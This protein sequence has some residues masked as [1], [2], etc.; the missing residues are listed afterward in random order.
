M[1]PQ[2]LV[3]LLV[4]VI[5]L[6]GAAAMFTR[7]MPAL[8][9]LPIMAVAIVSGTALLTQEISFRQDILAGVIGG[10]STRL[11]TAIIVAFFGGFLS[12]VMQKTGVAE[13][14]IKNAAE[15]IG[16]NPLGVSLFILAIVALLFTS[17]GGLGAIIMVA[18]V[19]L[20]MLSTVGVPPVVSGGILLI[21]IS[22]GGVLNPGNWVL[23]IEALQVPVVKVRAFALTVFVLMSLAGTIFV[24]V[25]LYRARVVRSA[26][27]ILL[28]VGIAIVLAGAVVWGFSQSNAGEG[29]KPY[30]LELFSSDFSQHVDIAQVGGPIQSTE[31]SKDSASF[32]IKT[33]QKASISLVATKATDTDA[34]RAFLPD[35]F[36]DYDRLRFTA[37]S[38]APADLT[39]N[40]EAEDAEPYSIPL[41]G[42]ATSAVE[43]T[44]DD[45]GIENPESIRGLSLALTPSDAMTSST[46]PTT[47]QITPISFIPERTV[48]I[49]KRI[50]QVLFGVFFAYLALM[51][52]MDFRAKVRRWR[53]Q[54][55]SIKWYA[56]LIPLV[57]LVMILIY[58]IDILAAF[59]IGFIYAI[60]V[61]L[62]PGSMSLT[63]QAMLQG[64]QAVL[65]AAMLMI[66]IGIMLNAVLGPPGWADLH[67]QKWPVS[68]ALEPLF[69]KVVPSSPIPYV[70]FFGILAPLALYRGPFNTWGL[71]F[72][73]ASVF[74]AVGLPEAA[75]M[76]MLMTV[77]QIQG[78]C[79][80]TNTHNVWLA[81]ELR[82]D[83][84]TLMW[85]TIPYIWAMVFVG[86][87]I[88]A[89]RVFGVS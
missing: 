5:F 35:K 15:L 16:D 18:I 13:S 84:Q 80:P 54:T 85:R 53:Q 12:F 81:N 66:G 65:P 82:V 38:S 21:G 9:V 7:F 17:I 23:Y 11:A 55:V 62:R 64:A 78:V 39:L 72:G 27:P 14:L 47:V 83:V 6:F 29:T 86:L 51:V 40:V 79:D 60:L 44:F 46:L 76:A 87:A 70:L 48:P 24:C 77:G 45:L 57:P 3:G 43:L 42:Y 28:T 67:G 63:V 8:L 20:P 61:T 19:F 89:V 68:A 33:D 30:R 56:Y 22:I 50:L 37:R 58:D 75:V 71:G 74:T 2:I 36:L 10:G 26:K 34:Y 52:F 59:V 88:A 49:W 25:E 73:V 4:L 41:G 31:I 32:A 1:D 69:S